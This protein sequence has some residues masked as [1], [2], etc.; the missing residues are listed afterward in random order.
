[1]R[2]AAPLA[3][4][5]D[6]LTSSWV[7]QMESHCHPGWRALAQS[8]LVAASTSQVHSIL[9]PQPPETK[10]AK[11]DRVCLQKRFKQFSCLRLPSSWGYRHPPPCPSNSTYIFLRWSLTLLP[12]LECSGVISV[13]RN[14]HLLDSSWS[15]T[16]D[17][18][19]SAHLRLLKCC[20]YRPEPLCPAYFFVLSIP[21]LLEC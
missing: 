14:L 20:D 9:L 10:G 4:F 7:F 21:C 1:M 16:P 19:R 5:P 3:F 12:R 11:S 17:L 8:G 15:R 13:H 18:K 6:S 2:P